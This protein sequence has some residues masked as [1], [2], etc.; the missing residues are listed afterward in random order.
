MTQTKWP[1]PNPARFSTAH[2]TVRGRRENEGFGDISY[3]FIEKAPLNTA[4]GM[5]TIKAEEYELYLSSMMVGF[6]GHQ[7]RLDP[8]AAAEQFWDDFLQQG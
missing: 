3:S 6:G 4:N 5:F 2:I 7:E 8:E 1:P